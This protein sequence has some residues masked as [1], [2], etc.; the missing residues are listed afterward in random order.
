[1]GHVMR[2]KLPHVVRSLRERLRVSARSGCA[3]DQA[4][5][6]TD[7]GPLRL[8]LGLG[9][10][11]PRRGTVHRGV[12]LIEVLFS[13]GIVAVGL[14]GVLIL[15]PLAGLRTT[16]GAMADGADRLGRNA[17]RAFDICQMRNQESWAWYDVASN[18]CQAF[19]GADAICID[20]LYVATYTAVGTNL[21][22]Y[23]PPSGAT[24]MDRITLR[25]YVSAAMPS[26]PPGAV[27]SRVMSLLQAGGIF[28]GEDD[29]VFNL[30]ADR[31]LPAEQK[32]DSSRVKRQWEGKFSWLAT[33]VRKQ[34]I[35][36]A[37]SNSDLYLLSIVVSHRRDPLIDAERTVE[38]APVPSTISIGYNGGDVL[39]SSTAE[40]NLK[41]KEGEWLILA[42]ID[43][44]GRKSFQ[45]YR[46][47]TADAG[48]VPNSAG[49]G[50]ERDLTLFG[51]DWPFSQMT[52]KTWAVWIPGV[53][54][55][56]E[57]T[58]RVPLRAESG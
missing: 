56:Y 50:Y 3:R 35:Q 36:G 34:T 7:V 15:V 14:L 29:L 25:S 6:L 38:V 2:W 33:L 10:I 11:R 46:I 44:S 57:K 23:N 12:T 24:Q 58:I 28:M 5:A 1:M 37:G 45:W 8:S 31:T 42:G 19:S 51:Q 54:A 21:F 52:G 55:V 17:I 40:D 22:P 16:Q 20:P 48:P 30:P 4:S 41:M 43:A 32:F 39:L 13:I 27:G 53:I 9:Q 18:T 26:P 47:Q 49:T